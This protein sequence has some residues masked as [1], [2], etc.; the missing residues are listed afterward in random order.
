MK[1]DLE[2]LTLAAKA[3]NIHWDKDA[4]VWFAKPFVRSDWNPLQDDG[5]ALRLA[6]KLRLHVDHHANGLEVWVINRGRR[7]TMRVFEESSVDHCA[8]TRRA[9]VRAAAHIGEAMPKPFL[10]ESIGQGEERDQYMGFP[11]ERLG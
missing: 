1:T 3:A 11:D 5:D 4:E 9:I 8:D 6:V 10:A 2:L 7:V